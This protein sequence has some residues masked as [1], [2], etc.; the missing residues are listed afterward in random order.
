MHFGCVFT[1]RLSVSAVGKNAGELHPLKLHLV[2]LPD[3]CI[4]SQWDSLSLTV[5]RLFV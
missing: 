5:N 2:F 3:E 4:A 1:H